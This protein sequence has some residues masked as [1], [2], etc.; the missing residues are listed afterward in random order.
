MKAQESVPLPQTSYPAVPQAHNIAQTG[1]P[2]QGPISYQVIQGVMPISQPYQQP[3]G[4]P[5]PDHG[6]PHQ[7]QQYNR[8]AGAGPVIPNVPQPPGHPT[9]LPLPGSTQAQPLHGKTSPSPAPASPSAPV[10]SEPNPPPDRSEQIALA[11]TSTARGTAASS[12]QT[13]QVIRKKTL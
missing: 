13:N 4:G 6:I 11:E 12:P 8:P 1:F 5:F 3:I 10:K 2:T 9:G 7:Y